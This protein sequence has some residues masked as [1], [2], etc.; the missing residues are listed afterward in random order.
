[1]MRKLSDREKSLLLYLGEIGRVPEVEFLVRRHQPIFVEPLN[2]GGMGSFRISLPQQ[3]ED[4][5]R[6]KVGATARSDDAD[7]VLLV[8]TLYLNERSYPY[9][10]DLWKADFSPTIE[11]PERWEVE[12]FPRLPGSGTGRK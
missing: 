7:G 2:D 5:Q 8:A 6:G 12:D 10:V 3:Y 1:M 9:E 11:L 4:V